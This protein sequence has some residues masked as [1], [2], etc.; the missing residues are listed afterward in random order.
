MLIVS[1]A[2]IDLGLSAFILPFIIYGESMWLFFT[3]L[4][5]CP[6]GVATV[7]YTCTK[8]NK[9]TRQ[10]RAVLTGPHS[11]APTN[12]EG[13]QSLLTTVLYT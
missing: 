8:H 6:V 3:R 11:G 1:L 2:I 9:E 7:V 13:P 10:I 5:A 4:L 12:T